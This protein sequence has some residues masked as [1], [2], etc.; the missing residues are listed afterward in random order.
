MSTTKEANLV[1]CLSVVIVLGIGCGPNTRSAA[2]L[3]CQPH[4]LQHEVSRLFGILHCGYQ[5]PNPSF[6]QIS[7]VTSEFQSPFLCTPA[8]VIDDSKH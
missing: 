5:A 4:M 1:K 2:G 6:T 3:H 8:V 7:S